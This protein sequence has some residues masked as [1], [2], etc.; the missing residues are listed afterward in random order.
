MVDSDRGDESGL[1]TAGRHFR[2]DF[3]PGGAGHHE[4]QRDRLVN[5]RDAFAEPGPGLFVVAEPR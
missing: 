3:R 1:A 4:F 5:E 2:H